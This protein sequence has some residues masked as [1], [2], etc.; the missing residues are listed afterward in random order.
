M[1]PAD[2]NANRT[3]ARVLGVMALIAVLWSA[4]E[5]LALRRLSEPLRTPAAP[6]G[7]VSLQLAPSTAEANLIVGDW[8]CQD[9]P[10][11]PCTEVRQVASDALARDSRF[12]L[13]YVAAWVLVALWAGVAAGLT[14]TLTGLIIAAIVAGGIFDLAENW[15]L[16]LA[17]GG[18]EGLPFARIAPLVPG[19]LDRV[20]TGETALH[21]HAFTLARLAAMTK[22]VLLLLGIAGALAVAGG[23]LRLRNIRRRLERE[24]GTAPSAETHAEPET[25]ITDFEGLIERETAGIFSGLPNRRRD[26]PVPVVHSAA[27]EPYVAFRAADIIGL[28]L[29]GGGIR[30]ATFNLGLL[31]GLHRRNLL[32][33]FD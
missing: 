23:G 12:V 31:Q 13:A 14:A 5:G 25:G 15:L 24:R 18:A 9:S 17:L 16:G 28:S 8:S 1:A 6:L 33:L 3:L 21:Q 29:S 32:R 20:T 2:S 4:Y 30:S 10:R 7:M 27:D 19:L 26:Y 11:D 22:F